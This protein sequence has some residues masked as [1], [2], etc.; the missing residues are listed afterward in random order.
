MRPVRP[1][2]RNRSLTWVIQSAVVFPQDTT[3]MMFAHRTNDAAK[4]AALD[5][6]QAI[7]EFDL[8]GR[9]L[10]ANSNFLAVVG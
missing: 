7:I 6:V 5:R 4:L 9:I 3:T 8:N 2:H 10:T 1:G